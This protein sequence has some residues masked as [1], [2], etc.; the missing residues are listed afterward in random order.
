VLTTLGADADA[1]ALARTLVEEQMAACVNVLPP[2]T[3]HYRWKGAVERDAERQLIIKTT[4]AR[5]ETL[6]ARLIQLHPY[7]LPEFLV[8][9]AAG[10]TKAY[11][12][13]LRESVLALL[14]V[15]LAAGASAQ[16][17]AEGLVGWAGFAD[18]ALIHHTVIGGALRQQLGGRVSVGPEIV[19][20]QG[21]GS[22]RDLF[23]TGLVAFDFVAPAQAQPGR[24]L[25][26]LAAGAGVFRHSDR[27]GATTS[28]SWEGT[29]T[30]GGGLRVALPRRLYAGVDARL[31]W[32]LHLRLAA[33]IG[34][35]FGS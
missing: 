7:E 5:V 30:A 10:G 32:E 16:T 28:S 8:I 15:L 21:P 35:T 11:L 20:M 22:D 14:F 9:E 3:S 24:V 27:F 12:Q 25:P 31:G 1:D 33:T 4:A 34:H 23:L 29:F 13:W 18:D 6:R 19:F 2:M 17:S 26:Y